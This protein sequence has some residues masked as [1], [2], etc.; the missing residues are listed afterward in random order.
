MSVSQPSREVF[1]IDIPEVKDF[2]AA[3]RYNFFTPD[4]SVNES[5]GV[6]V[7]AMAKHSDAHDA[8]FVQYSTTRVPRVVQFSFTLP[9][10][11]D[12][13]NAT[14]DQSV[15]N[16]SFKTTGEQDGSLIINNIDKVINEDYFSGNGFISVSFHDGSIDDKVFQLVSGTIDQQ[17]L[18][19]AHPDSTSPAKA[20]QSFA[21]SL[22]STVSTD[23]VVRAMAQPDIAH[24]S[25]F[26]VPAANAPG[27]GLKTGLSAPDQ[28]VPYVNRYFERLKMVTTNAQINAKLFHDMVDQAI[29]DPSATNAGDLVSLHGY[30]KAAEL[31]TNQRFSP[32]LSDQD[33][34]TFVPF[35]VVTK[36]STATHV[37]K[38][39]AELVGYIIDKY[40]VLPDGSTKA[41]APIVIDNP[42]SNVVADYL[43]KFNARYCY[44]VRTVALMTIP[45]IDDA[46]GNVA[47]LKILV[48]SKPSNKVYV[49]TLKLDAPP[50]PGDVKFTWNYET[51]KLLVSWAFPVT[52]ERDIK[53]FQIYR[54]SS[55]DEPFELQKVYDFDDSVVPFPNP[56]SPDPRFIEKLTSPA[57]FWID[58]EFDMT[59]N[60]TAPAG[61]IYAVCAIDAHG[62]TSNYSAQFNVWFDPFKNSLQ[63]QLV[64]HAGAPKPYPNL[65]L[66]ADIFTDTIKTEG[67][68][69]KRLKLYFNPEYYF[70]YDDQDRYVKVLQTQQAG[71]SYQ[72]QFLNIDNVKGQ[73]ISITIDDRL[74][75]SQQTL[76]YPTF[77]VGPRRKAQG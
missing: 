71:G 12:P 34:K 35:V 23:F 6:P 42:L 8:A 66:D 60:K 52:S 53:Q 77:K 36:Q 50:P 4:E 51:N 65:Y 32:A 37:Q 26:R 56:E 1:A 11:A 9:R 59:V 47:T 40:E 45:A 62:L 21:P 38:Y 29:K 33:Y 49:S 13:G 54:R 58:D 74:N 18:G 5:G 48:S 55:V 61:F 69:S 44:C 24:G 39:A 68:S 63:K 25:T 27:P 20:A 28:G 67:S 43:V 73:D 30:T 22:P 3:F 14:N 41:H 75:A 15:R 19:E 46:T 76:A 17:S 57:T 64:S 7:D 2:A 31:A 70:L 72:L 16:A 10:L